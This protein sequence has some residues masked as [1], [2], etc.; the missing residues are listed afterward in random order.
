MKVR[1][2]LGSLA[3]V[4][5]F[6]FGVATAQLVQTASDSPQ[7]VEQ[8]RTDLTGA[9]DTQVIASVAE[10]RPG[11]CLAL[12][13]HRGVEAAYV[14]Q[15]ASVQYA[16]KAPVTLSTGATVLNLRDVPHAGFKVVGGTSLKPFTVHIVDKGTPLYDFA[17]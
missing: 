13:G 4:F 11:D 10:Y 14:L 3:G 6:G 15:G 17:P 5:C 7:R 8:K 1:A 16:G 12:H 9:P 2:L